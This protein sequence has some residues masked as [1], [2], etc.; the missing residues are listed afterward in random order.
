MFEIIKFITDWQNKNDKTFKPVPIDT[1][2]LIIFH[3]G[4]QIFNFV[5]SNETLRDKCNSDIPDKLLDDFPYI[6]DQENGL[7]YYGFK[8]D[9]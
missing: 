8:K 7:T 1:Q 6:M 2:S 9:Y 3:F 5:F 4:N